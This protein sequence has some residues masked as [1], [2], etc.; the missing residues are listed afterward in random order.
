MPVDY[1]ILLVIDAIGIGIGLLLIREA[2]KY[3]ARRIVGR[4]VKNHHGREYLIE[5]IPDGVIVVKRT[6]I[7]PSDELWLHEP[8]MKKFLAQA[9]QWI[10][11]NPP[12]ENNLE[13][14]EAELQGKKHRYQRQ[15]EEQK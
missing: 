15:S 4:N 8:A 1:V 9:G 5:I 10:R 6:V 14:L 7:V 13:E 12:K 11:D 2:K 3:R